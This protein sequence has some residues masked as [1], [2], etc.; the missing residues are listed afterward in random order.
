MRKYGIVVG[1][2]VTVA[3]ALAVPLL[4]HTQHVSGDDQLVSTDENPPPITP[5]ALLGIG[6]I[7]CQGEPPDI[8]VFTPLEQLG[9]KI[10]YDCTLSNPPGYACAQC[11]QAST[12]FTTP[13]TNGSDINLLIGCPPGNVPGRFDNRRAMSYAYAAFSPE[14]PYY[15][16]TFAMAYVGG[17]FWDGRV[18][19][20]TGQAMQPFMNPDEMNNTPTNGIYPPVLGGYAALVAEKA[21]TKY[22]DLFEQAYGPGILDMT[23]P[24]MACRPRMCTR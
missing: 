11:H 22:K 9:K 18:P 23:P 14:G 10:L 21:T 12:G 4:L 3:C 15:D 13:A 16:A 5:E 1:T 17:C 8:V 2:A 20:L 24:N 6:P 7:P 19:D